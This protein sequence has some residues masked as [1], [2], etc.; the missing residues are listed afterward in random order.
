MRLLKADEGCRK[1]PV[2]YFSGWENIQKLAAEA[3]GYLKKSFN[4][5]EMV[6]VVPG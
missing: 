1:I 3:D 4:I 2:I 6:A 5:D